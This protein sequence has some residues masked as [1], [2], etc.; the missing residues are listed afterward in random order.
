MPLLKINHVHTHRT[1]VV[2]LLQS[3]RDWIRR[4]HEDGGVSDGLRGLS[5]QF[6]DPSRTVPQGNL[7]R[8][9]R[10]AYI[11]RHVNLGGQGEPDCETGGCDGK[12]VAVDSEDVR[13]HTGRIPAR[14]SHLRRCGIQ[15]GSRTKNHNAST[16]RL[17]PSIGAA[18]RQPSTYLVIESKRPYI[19]DIGENHEHK[20]IE[21]N[22]SNCMCIASL[23]TC[24]MRAK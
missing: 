20:A 3:N 5:R 6:E 16:W 9:L 22:C 13:L 18:A 10:R 19:S 21:S 7:Q 14:R 1:D 8:G 11:S 15:H 17:P 4:Y 23:R 12:D 2:R 24:R